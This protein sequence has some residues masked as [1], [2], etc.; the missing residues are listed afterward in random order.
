MAVRV[1][2]AGCLTRLIVN[3]GFFVSSDT[4]PCCIAGGIY[5]TRIGQAQLLEWHFLRSFTNWLHKGLWRMMLTWM[6]NVIP[7]C[8]CLFS[9]CKRRWSFINHWSWQG[10][11]NRCWGCLHDWVLSP[12]WR[13]PLTLLTAFLLNFVHLLTRCHHTL[14]KSFDPMSLFSPRVRCWMFE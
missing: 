4:A 14:S 10:H 1:W 9:P 11:S 3:V 7:T 6:S 13:L 12:D 2:S 5:V 8:C